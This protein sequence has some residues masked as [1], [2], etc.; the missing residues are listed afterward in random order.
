MKRRNFVRN[1]AVA[2][3]AAPLVSPIRALGASS[4]DRQVRLGGPVYPDEFD[5]PESWVAAI[6]D[7]GYRAVNTPFRDD[8]VDESV[9]Q[10][11]VQAARNADIVIAEVGAW[12]NPIS[13]LEDVRKAALE[14]CI[15]KLDLADQLGARCCVNVSGSRGTETIGAPHP[16]NLTDETF[17]MIV[18]VTRKIIDAVRPTRTYFALEAMPYALPD[19]TDGYLDLIKA[20]DRNKFAAHFDPVNLMNSPRRYFNNGA[21][22]KEA[23]K[24]LGIYIRSC[25]AK[26][27]LLTTKLTAHFDEVVPGT[28][29]LDYAVYLQEIAKLDGVPLI[30]EHMKRE[31]Y[32][33]AAAYIRKIGH[34]NGIAV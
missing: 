17:D 33:L 29:Y 20:I 13:P 22:I 1:L 28:G 31:E 25:H 27:T 4:T 26:D 3:I 8:P 14:K 24:K 5:S 16:L 23:F 19:S 10:A 32:P 9:V 2:A 21:L 30:M 12:S 7:K 15:Q 34:K 6:R 11:Y 18:E